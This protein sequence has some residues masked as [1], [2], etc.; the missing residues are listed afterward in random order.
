MPMN[1]NSINRVYLIGHLGNR[2]EGR[3]TPSGRPT[4]N[5]SL[6]TNEVWKNNA[7][8]QVEHTE[9]HHI[10]VWDK[11][12]DFVTEY[13]QKGQLI[14]IEGKLQTRTYKDKDDVQHW[15]TEVISNV[16]TPLEWKTA[17]KKENGLTKKTAEKVS[18]PAGAEDLPF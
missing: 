6:A 11:L 14:Y 3:Y 8:K 1:K 16:I 9:W 2:P 10:V 5:F 13:L 17:A 7:G 12:A 4:V 15:K 18:E